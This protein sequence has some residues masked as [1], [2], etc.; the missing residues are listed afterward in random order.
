MR[1]SSLKIALVGVG[2]IGSTFAYYLAKAGHEVTVVA[3]PNSTR[4]AQL[5][6]DGGIITKAGERA[7]AQVADQLDE[8]AFYDLVIV[9][10]LAHQADALLPSLQRSKARRI[11]FMFNTFQPERLRDAMGGDRSSF[12]M[13]FVMARLDADG[14]LDA[15]VSASRKTL[16][17]DQRWADLFSNAGIASAFEPDMLLWLRCHVP[18]CIAMESISVMAQASGGGASWS[19]AMAVAQ[20]PAWRLCHHQGPWLPICTPKAKAILDVSPNAV[21]AGMLWSISR[22]G[23]LSVT[24]LATGAI[25]CGTLIDRIIASAQTISPV[26]AAAVQALTKIR[27]AAKQ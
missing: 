21:L 7:S 18:L 8:E 11:H 6:R 4:H 24:L 26:P 13:P 20:R 5:K 25:E 17:S 15:T 16:H 12:G 19:D 22:V 9:T 3:R 10:V 14:R 2:N 1:M 27:P 23:S